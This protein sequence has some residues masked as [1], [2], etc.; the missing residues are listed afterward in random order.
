LTHQTKQ[1]LPRGP[2]RALCLGTPNWC[3]QKEANIYRSNFIT[4]L[5]AGANQQREWKTKRNPGENMQ[6]VRKESVI[7]SRRK[8]K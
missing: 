3:P 5:V 8:K 2:A 4:C 7:T 1:Q 6:Q